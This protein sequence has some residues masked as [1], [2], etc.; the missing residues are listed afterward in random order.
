MCFQFFFCP[1]LYQI[2]TSATS[3]AR[4]FRNT[5]IKLFQHSK[6][7]DT[8]RGHQLD[9][10][11]SLKLTSCYLLIRQCSSKTWAHL[12]FPPR[13]DVCVSAVVFGQLASCEM[14]E[15]EKMFTGSCVHFG[16]WYQLWE[17]VESTRDAYMCRTKKTGGWNVLAAERECLAA[18][19]LTGGG[20][21][22]V[23]CA[24]IDVNCQKKP[25]QITVTNVTNINNS[26]LSNKVRMTQRFNEQRWNP[27]LSQ[28]QK[29][30][31]I[32]CKSQVVFVQFVFFLPP[33]RCEL[34]LSHW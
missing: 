23:S 29:S 34:H 22:S 8:W 20:L 31:F 12:L 1:A 10:F 7:S 13:F 16:L 5:A 6:M 14:A 33:L 11:K 9:G 32:R 27:T 26:W 21:L 17:C 19:R 18:N 25:Q 24:P 15:R 3:K 28:P 30:T 2:N 4:L